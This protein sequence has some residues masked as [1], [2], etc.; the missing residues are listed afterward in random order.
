MLLL[1]FQM[2]NER[3]AVR[4]TEVIE[5]LPLTTIRKL[6]QAPKEL[7]GLLDYRHH[8]VPVIDL[9]QLTEKRTHHKVLSSRIIVM[10]YPLPDREEKIAIIAE[11][12]TDTI[13]IATSSLT[14]SHVQLPNAPYLGEIHNESG[15]YVQLI[16]IKS[17]LTP[18][19]QALL[20]QNKV[21]IN[22]PLTNSG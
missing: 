14:D 5:I 4:A 9:V 16:E 18:D 21:S 2:G 22:N 11:K 13:N 19:I 8:T 12:V 3:Y 10:K 20:F 7:A 17:I 6:P 1:T 15:E